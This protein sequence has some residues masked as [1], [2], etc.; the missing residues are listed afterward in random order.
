MTIKNAIL[1]AGGAGTRLKPFTNIYNKQLLYLAGK[2]VIDY[3]IKTLT[4]LG[5]E[6]IIITLG[7][8]F[9][10]QIIDYCGNGEKYGVNITYVYQGNPEGI[11]H[12]INLCHK[13]VASDDQF[14]VILGD[15]WFE[16][17]VKLSNNSAKIFLYDHENLH[18]FGV[19]SIEDNKIVK[20]EEKPKVIDTN[21]KN[22]AIT[23]LYSFDHKFFEYFAKSKKSSRN[24]YE[25]TSIIEA[26]HNDK[27]LDYEVISGEWNDAGT[28]ENLNY[29]NYKLY[30]GTH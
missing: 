15:N 14:L 17:P 27:L 1:L 8:S 11:S 24:E 21:Y 22:Y 26:Y 6:N 10:G 23:G 4:D 12:A 30:N 18:A 9:A 16:K 20:I 28:I 2:A 25:I 13:Y 19:A 3:P 5:V 29:L 7:S